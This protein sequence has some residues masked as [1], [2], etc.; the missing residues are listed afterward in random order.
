MHEPS[1]KFHKLLHPEMFRYFEPNRYYHNFEHILYMLMKYAE[2]QKHLN[3][4]ASLYFYEESTLLEA[5]LWH[6]VIYTPGSKTNELESAQLYEKSIRA[7]PLR[8]REDTTIVYDLIMS[9]SKHFTSYTSSERWAKLTYIMMD[10]DLISFAADWNVFYRNNLNIM[11]EA[12]S[13]LE[14]TSQFLQKL[15]DNADEW[16]P[17]RSFTPEASEALRRKSVANLD[18]WLHQVED[19][20]ET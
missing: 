2:M 9:T 17:F 10:L 19:E 7:N 13:T 4:G 15:R 20:L 8:F 5:I 12:D 1:H 14:Q 11:L 3:F 6:D 16:L 18:R